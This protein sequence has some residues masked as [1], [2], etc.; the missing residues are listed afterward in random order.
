MGGGGGIH[1]VAA[2]NDVSS[3]LSCKPGVFL[4]TSG[5]LR[6]YFPTLINWLL[7]CEMIG[8]FFLFKCMQDSAGM[9]GFPL[10]VFK[11]VLL[12]YWHSFP[13]CHSR[14]HLFGVPGAL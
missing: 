7:F 4:L 14:C 6:L 8:G 13:C 1:Q 3:S 5:F 11:K 2:Q 10:S 9:R 12:P